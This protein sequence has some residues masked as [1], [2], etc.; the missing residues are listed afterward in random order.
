M[1]LNAE[2]SL[3]FYAFC[4]AGMAKVLGG[5]FVEKEIKI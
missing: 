5:A 3:V 2:M 4:N 1:L